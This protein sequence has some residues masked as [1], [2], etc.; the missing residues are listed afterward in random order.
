MTQARIGARRGS[1]A[2]A[3]MVA[4]A[5]GGCE[6]PSYDDGKLVPY[7]LVP[8]GLDCAS[9][10]AVRVGDEM[11]VSYDASHEYPD[12]IGKKG[13]RGLEKAPL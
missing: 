13:A 1:T 9:M 6:W 2:I 11:R 10:T 8:G 12:G 7:C 3:F 4:A 5:V